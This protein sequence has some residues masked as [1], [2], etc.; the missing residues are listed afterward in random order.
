MLHE[1]E[2]TT[3]RRL[4]VF[5]EVP[6][7]GKASAGV[8]EAKGKAAVAEVKQHSKFNHQIEQISQESF[9]TPAEPDEVIFGSSLEDGSKD[10]VLSWVGTALEDG[11]KVARWM[12]SESKCL[13][14]TKVG[15]N[16]AATKIM[17]WG[18]IPRFGEN[19]DHGS[20]WRR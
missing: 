4:N 16:R 18:R 3:I 1:E 19:W 5:L 7:E 15:S 8:K 12:R 13:D 17:S 9:N 14:L 10:S 6:Q 2:A 11:Y 20:T